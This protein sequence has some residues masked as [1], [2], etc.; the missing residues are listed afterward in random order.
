MTS[1][2]YEDLFKTKYN[3]L[4]VPSDTENMNTY[5]AATAWARC[6]FYVLPIDRQTKHAGSVVGT[7]WPE[8]SSRNP[9]QIAEWF[10][11]ERY[12]L[13]IHVGKSGAIAFDVDDPSCVPYEL[14]QWMHFD[15]TPF[16]STRTD[17]PKRGHYLFATQVGKNYGNSKG[18][19]RGGW[20]EVRGKNGIIV[21]SPTPHQKSDSGGRYLWLRTGPLP[22]MPQDLAEQL[23]DAPLLSFAAFDLKQVDGFLA[24]YNDVLAPEVLHGRMEAARLKFKV[25]SRHEAA[26]GLLLVCLREAMAGLY[27]A[28]LAVESVANL[29]IHFKPKSEWSSPDEFLGMVRWAVAQVAATSDSDLALIRDSVLTANSMSVARWLKELQ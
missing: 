7:G 16:Q 26:V 3:H 18:L 15:G 17:D 8:K 13:A 19:M 4:E 20:G 11:A 27:P 21:V 24:Q 6:G 1:I 23:P 14:N 9:N 5:E 10:R 29:F 25:G 2:T 28:K 12:G 22:F